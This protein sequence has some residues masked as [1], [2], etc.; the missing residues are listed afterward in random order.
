MPAQVSI[1]AMMARVEPQRFPLQAS[2]PAQPATPPLGG[3]TF[4]QKLL[5]YWPLIGALVFLLFVA[6][7]LILLFALWR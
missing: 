6:L 7:L 5:A 3:Q 2:P 4:E 1:P